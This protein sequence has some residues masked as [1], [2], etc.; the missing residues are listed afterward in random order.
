MCLFSFP[1][2]KEILKMKE[3]Y[4]H[5]RKRGHSVVENALLDDC[6]LSMQAKYLLIQLCS[7]REG[8]WKV[9]MT[10]II[11]RSKNG[12]DAHYTALTELIHNK[13]VARVKVILKGKH[14]H[15]VY[16][17]G[18]VKEDVAETLEDVI[19][20]EESKGFICRVEFGEPLP[21][22]Q[23]TV[24]S[25]VEIQNNINNQE[26][27]TNKKTNNPNINNIDDDKRTSPS[28]EDSAIHNEESINLIISNFRELTKDDLS[29][30][31]F[32]SVVR[33]VVDKYNQGKINNFRDY[34][35]TALNAKIQE[36][37]LRRLKDQA[38]DNI[39]KKQPE[40]P[41][42]QPYRQKVPFYNWLEE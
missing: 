32:K 35:V 3:T 16:V 1:G 28:G 33:K 34:L 15:Q 6:Q 5:A 21:E 19:K 31:S 42:Q 18:Q 36:L 2:E 17:F 12:R 10:D 29:D 40:A 7:H 27:K 41:D 39:A 20:A 38:K 25:D 8:E 13:Y 22:N 23:D 4:L 24:K 30:R 11:K 26:Q 14:D 9:N 37:E